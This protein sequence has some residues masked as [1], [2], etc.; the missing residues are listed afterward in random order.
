M[1]QGI[2][3][4]I[5]TCEPSRECILPPQRGGH[6]ALGPTPL[7]LGV[8]LERQRIGSVVRNGGHGDR[9]PVGSRMQPS[10][11]ALEGVRPPHG[12]LPQTYMGFGSG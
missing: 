11:R 7:G 2:V 9:K 3:G 8:V 1:H 5:A 10:R 12:P 6:W 4:N